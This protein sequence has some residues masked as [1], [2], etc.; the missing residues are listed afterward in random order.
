MLPVLDVRALKRSAQL[1]ALSSLFDEIAEM[2]FER[3]P[4]MAHCPARRALD[5]G[6]SAI[7]GLPD[8][9]RL[10]ELLASEPVVANRRL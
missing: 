6:L 10:R 3:L 2:E 1:Q 7:L 9:S 5:D 4:A 8:L